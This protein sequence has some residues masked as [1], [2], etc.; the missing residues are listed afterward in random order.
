MDYVNAFWVGGL[1]CAVAQLLIDFTKLTPARILTG[2]VV[3]G[4][5][6]SA[7]G[8]YG[9]FAEF[10]GA[11]A[12]VPLSGFGHVMAQGVKEA[13]DTQGALGIITG[14]ISSAAAGICVAI[15]L[16]LAASIVG[17]SRLK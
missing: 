5:A 14:G 16:G 9:P 17:K 10:A 7:A 1:I 4:V 8:L 11:G 12:T 15:I 6:T 3:L 2:C 13:V